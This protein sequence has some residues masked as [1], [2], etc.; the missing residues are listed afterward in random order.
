MTATNHYLVG[1]ASAV[2]LKN[3]LVVLPV[4][5][6]SHFV[7]DLLP[8]FGLGFDKERGKILII[9]AGI[10]IVFLILA[11]SMTVNKYPT[12]YICSGI[13]AYMPDLAWIYRFIFPEKFGSLSPGPENKFNAWHS[14]LQKYER[15]WGAFIEIGVAG[16]LF[17]LMFF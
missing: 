4:A 14:R 8:H 15:W 16:L 12:W 5:F 2:L 7:L 13:V 1:V 17:T 6:A 3:P 10:D 11:I 9:T